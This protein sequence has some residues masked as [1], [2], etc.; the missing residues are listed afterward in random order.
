MR[1]ITVPKQTPM[2][3]CETCQALFDKKD[4]AEKC[5]SFH[6][7]MDSMTIAEVRFDDGDG[8]LPA[9]ILIESGGA[10]AVYDRK[11]EGSVED[12]TEEEGGW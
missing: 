3:E 9:G 7:K 12:F 1:R 11:R 6:F 2:W 5:E 10:A 4:E 8:R